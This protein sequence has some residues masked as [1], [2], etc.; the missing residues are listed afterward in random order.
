MGYPIKNLQLLSMFD[1]FSKGVPY[2]KPSS[3]PQN[4]SQSKTYEE[5]P[6][7]KLSHLHRMAD[8]IYESARQNLLSSSQTKTYRN[9]EAGIE[10]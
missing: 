5:Q 3:L 9:T 7:Q 1:I 4:K 10:S 8:G 2:R 6:K